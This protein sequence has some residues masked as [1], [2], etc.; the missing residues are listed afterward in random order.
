MVIPFAFQPR[1]IRITTT[2][3]PQSLTSTKIAFTENQTPYLEHNEPKILPANFGAEILIE[4]CIL[5]LTNIKRAKEP[6]SGISQRSL[7]PL[8]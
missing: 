3:S 2:D 1:K 7:R 4:C 5:S 6:R 8:N